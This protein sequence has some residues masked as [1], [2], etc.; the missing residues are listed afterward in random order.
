M[1]STTSDGRSSLGLHGCRRFFESWRSRPAPRRQGSSDRRGGGP[2]R[3]R[4][5]GLRDRLETAGAIA[6][7]AACRTIQIS[8]RGDLSFAR[9][10]AA[11]ESNARRFSPSSCR[12][13]LSNAGLELSFFN[14]VLSSGHSVCEFLSWRRHDRPKHVPVWALV[15]RDKGLLFLSSAVRLRCTGI[16]TLPERKAAPGEGVL[17]PSPSRTRLYRNG[18]VKARR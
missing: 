4:F 11:T 6:A 16:R 13:R 9:L 10:I 3:E 17:E 12:L 2:E 15:S 7:R 1:K 18:I 5:A 8:E 14:S